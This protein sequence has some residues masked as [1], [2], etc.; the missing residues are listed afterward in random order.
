MKRGFCVSHL[1]HPGTEQALRRRKAGSSRGNSTVCT[2]LSKEFGVLKTFVSFSFC[3]LR[4]HAD[5]TSPL[6]PMS[7]KRDTSHSGRSFPLGNSIPVVLA[8]SPVKP[9]VDFSGL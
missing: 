4:Y 2:L 5:Y 9:F 8:Q 6:H 7:K 1:L 3:L